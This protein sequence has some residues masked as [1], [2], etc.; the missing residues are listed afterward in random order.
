M[1]HRLGLIVMAPA[2]GLLVALACAA[3]VPIGTDAREE[4]FEIPKG[5]WARRRAGNP[6]DILP[7][8]INLVLEVRDVLVLRIWHGREART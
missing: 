1:T 6:V 8:K 4:L 5:T 2:A 7:S 3:L